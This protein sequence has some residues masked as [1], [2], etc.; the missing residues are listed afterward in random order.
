MLNS[1]T[2]FPFSWLEANFASAKHS[3]EEW[4]TIFADSFSVDFFRSTLRN[5]MPVLR[6]NYY[7]ATMPAYS[8]LGPKFCPLSYFSEKTF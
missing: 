1:Q 7:G 6:S 5:A 8:Y 3:A 4:Q 2:F